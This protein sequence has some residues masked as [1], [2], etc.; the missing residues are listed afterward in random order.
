M[1]LWDQLRRPDSTFAETLVEHPQIK[2]ILRPFDLVRL[3]SPQVAQ[4]RLGSGQVGCSK[5]VLEAVLIDAKYE[6][7]LAKQQRMVAGLRTLDNKKLPPDLDYKTVVHLRAEAVEKLSAF[8]PATLGQ[9]AR[10]SGVTPADITVLQ[11]HLKKS[12]KS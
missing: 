2:A 5:D 11:V 7:Y 9:A 12:Y 3:R 4:G 1:S 6:G 10:I 8:R